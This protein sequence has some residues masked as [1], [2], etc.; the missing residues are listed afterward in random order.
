MTIIFWVV[1]SSVTVSLISVIGILALAVKKETLDKFLLFLVSFSV[2][3]LLGDAFLHLLPEA[4]DS[5][6]HVVASLLCVAGMLIFFIL[7]RFLRWRH[8]HASGCHEHYN[9]PL[10]FMNIFGDMAHNTID[11]LLIGASY[12]ISMELGIATTV[13]II[14]HEI[15][16]EIGNFGVLLHAGLSAKKAVMLNLISGAAAI[17][18]ALISLILGPRVGLYPLYLAPIAAGG[19]IYVAG[20]DLIPELH[21]EESASKS[22]FQLICVIL[23]V[24]LMAALLLLD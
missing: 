9:K 6:P 4:F 17:L 8:C 3:G 23:G 11:G 21:K 1:A 18:G 5:L 15:P 13:A 12:L 22:F 19:F 24:G 16:H 10:A 20:S 7:E 14:S 2:G